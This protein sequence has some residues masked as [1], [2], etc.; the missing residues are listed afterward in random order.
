MKNKTDK[1]TGYI[2]E[3]PKQQPLDMK[4]IRIEGRWTIPTAGL[5]KTKCLGARTHKLL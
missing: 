3:F 5:T 2:Y 1:R 4:W